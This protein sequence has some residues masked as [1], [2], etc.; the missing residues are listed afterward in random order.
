MRY[1]TVQP[2]AVWEAIQ[3]QGTCLVD[4]SLVGHVPDCY[5]WL[6]EQ[7][8]QRMRWDRDHLPWWLYCGKPDL[9]WVRWTRPH[10]QWEVRL[11]LEL[12]PERVQEMMIRDWDVVYCRGWLFRDHRKRHRWYDFQEARGWLDLENL[13]DPW[14]QRLELSWQR[15]FDPTRKLGQARRR[16]EAVVERIERADVVKARPFLGTSPRRWT[17]ILPSGAGRAEPPARHP[18]CSPPVPEHP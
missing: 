4:P 14:P 5:L 1:W 10:Q 13:P 2:V 17:N 9:R 3:A 6:V 16:L 8:R 12:P 11:E 18:A 15:V 7:L